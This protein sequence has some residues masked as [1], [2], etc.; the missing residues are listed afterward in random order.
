MSPS[1]DRTAYRAALAEI[2]AKAKAVLPQEVNGRL[3]GAVALVLQDDVWPQEDGSIQVGSCTDA[4]KV[5]RLVGASCECKDFTDGKAPQGWCRH[6]IAAGLHKR[7]R[8]TLAAQAVASPAP[9]ALPE[10]PASLNLRAMINGYEVQI[11]LR[12]T[13]EAALLTR[14]EALLTR[15]D[16]RP[17]PKPAP[18]SGGSWR[19]GH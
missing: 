16:V 12:D 11:T 7:V 18:R 15:A 8:E 9:Q 2:A 5:Y 1:P 4:T 17:V 3:E 13:N 14:V 10:A 6:R 19:K